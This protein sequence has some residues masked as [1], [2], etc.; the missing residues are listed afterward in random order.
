MKRKI[1]S[2]LIVPMALLFMGCPNPA[3][4]APDPISVD[5][6]SPNIGT[7]KYVPAGTFRRD[8]VAGHDSTVSAFRMSQYE[9]TRAQ[10]AAIMG[11]D[12]SSTSDSSGTGDSVQRVNWYHT[13]AF[14]NKLSIAEGLTPVYSV[15]G[16]DFSTLAYAEIPTTSDAAW[17]SA[18][19][20][21]VNDGYRLPTV[22]EWMWA[23]MGALP[24]EKAAE[25]APWLTSRPFR[26]VTEAMLLG[27]MPGTFR[28]VATRL[29]PPALKPQMSWMI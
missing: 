2:L 11:T 8:G 13:I 10:F 26:A 9:I 19:V 4:T 23:A 25:L 21:W 5:Y 3:T 16:I 6:T 15:L 17:D 18:A 1:I 28:T 24:T 14:C 7:L 22:M 12:P 20:T 27:T 29:I